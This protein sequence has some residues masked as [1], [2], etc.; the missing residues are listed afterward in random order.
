[1]KFTN[2]QFGEMEFES[3]H[4]IEIPEGIVGF[5]ENRRFLIVDDADSQPF[6]WLVSLEDPDLSFAMMDT[7]GYFPDYQA[8]FFNGHDVSVFHFVALKDPLEASSVNLRSPLVIDN[9]NRK[10]QQVILDDDTL[11]MRFPLFL[12]QSE[13]A[14]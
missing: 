12:H 5:Q 10:A 7:S 11:D 3:R 8:K 13:S 1:M 14:E 2:R 6:R 4:I 9:R